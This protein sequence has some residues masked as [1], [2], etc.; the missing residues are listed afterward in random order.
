MT[1][2]ATSHGGPNRPGAQRGSALLVVLLLI[3][4]MSALA[5]VVS[6]SVSGAA[7][8]MSAAKIN[9]EREWDIRAG[10]E[11]GVASIQSLGEGVRSGEA[12]TTLS[13][14]RIQVSFVNE[15][16]RVDLNAASLP[17]LKALMVAAGVIDSDADALARNIIEWRGG[18]ASQ[19]LKSGEE[20][21]PFSGFGKP[22][23]TDLRPGSELREAPKQTV[24]TRFFLH[25][26]QLASVPGF[27]KTLVDSLMPFI[28]VANG[29]NQVDPYIAPRAVLLAL[30][31]ATPA[32]VD[33]FLAGRDQNSGLK[34]AT[35]LMGVSKTQLST[36]AAPGWRMEIASTGKE[37]RV[38]HS[39]AEIAVIT[40]DSEPYRVLYVLDTQ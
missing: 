23:G 28:T 25:P 29:S 21:S 22:A 31:G 9:A 13:D 18:S 20:E 16:A 27:S 24:G 11:L 36:S 32:T 33:A 26:A 5:V 7:L 15:R 12:W 30:P 4:A 37:G 39:S 40:G 2:S 8:E 35:L 19:E 34:F 6:R 14:R 1:G 10:I 38:H 17:V 3:G